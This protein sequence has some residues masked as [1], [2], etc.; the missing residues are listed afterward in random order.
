MFHLQ[1]DHS[2]FFYITELKNCKDNKLK[3]DASLETSIFLLSFVN[4]QVS[5]FESQKSLKIFH[6]VPQRYCMKYKNR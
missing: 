5:N 3:L 2:K 4:L 6:R 1:R